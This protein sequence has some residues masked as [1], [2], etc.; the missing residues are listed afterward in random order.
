M[1]QKWVNGSATNYGVILWATNENTDGKDLRFHS[2]EYTIFQNLWPKL[3][4]TYSTETKTVYFLKDHLG[5]IRATVL[6]SVGAPVIGYDD[7]DPWG[8]V[9]AGRSM[10]SSILPL[11]T[12]N[13]FTGKERD[14]EHGVNWD[15]FG[16]RYYDAQIGRWFVVDPLALKHSNVS[17]YAYVLNNPLILIDPDGKQSRFVVGLKYTPPPSAQQVQQN[18]SQSLQEAKL[19]ASIGLLQQAGGRLA[20]G[21]LEAVGGAVANLDPYNISGLANPLVVG[22]V[23]N[24]A[25]RSGST[26]RIAK[27]TGDIDKRTKLGKDLAKQTENLVSETKDVTE[28]FTKMGDAL[29]EGEKLSGSKEAT[30]LA[31][32]IGVALKSQNVKQGSKN[33][34]QKIINFFKKEEKPSN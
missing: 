18:F 5:S 4:I 23:I 1:T 25:L 34:F 12:R 33:F 13:K 27:V 9:L 6:D 15:Y 10:A 28:E 24:D 8:Y 19:L 29:A 16:A 20:L 26:I 31:D 14:D 2:S 30:G 7:Y 17:P 3:E 11:T 21:S 32:A 22:G